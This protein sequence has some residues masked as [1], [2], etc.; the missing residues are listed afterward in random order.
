[1]HYVILLA[2]CILVFIFAKSMRTSMWALF[3]FLVG[4]V[5][6]LFEYPILG[7]VVLVSLIALI[8]VYR[9]KYYGKHQEKLNEIRRAYIRK[10]YY[11]I[12]ELDEN[13]HPKYDYFLVLTEEEKRKIQQWYI[14]EWNRNNRGFCKKLEREIYRE[15]F[16][17]EPYH[18]SRDPDFRDK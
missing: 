17:P 5:C 8:W 11:G 4:L 18:N 6:L 14:D 13:G 16:H 12:E 2:V 10:K 7:L 1:M 3:F 15:I 9:A